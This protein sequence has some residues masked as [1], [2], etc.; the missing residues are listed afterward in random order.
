MN[1]NQFTELKAQ[2]GLLRLKQVLE[3]IPV[4]KSTWWEGVKDGRFPQPVKLGPNT[5]AWHA[6]DIITYIESLS[7]PAQE[8]VS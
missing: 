7:A 1:T 8:A 5:T 4:S 2:Y 6:R 3:I